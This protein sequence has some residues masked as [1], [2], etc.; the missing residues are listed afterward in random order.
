VGNTDE[1]APGH[2]REGVAR[3]TDLAVDLETTAETAGSVRY[4]LWQAG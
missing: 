3:G 4:M 1:R 2:T